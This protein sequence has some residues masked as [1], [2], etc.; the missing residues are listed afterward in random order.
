MELKEVKYV[1]QALANGRID[2]YIFGGWALDILRGRKTRE[3]RDLD[4]C[5]MSKD[6]PMLNQILGSEHFSRVK[7]VDGR[8]EFEHESRK[9]TVDV[10]KLTPNDS[11]LEVEHATVIGMQAFSYP[12]RQRYI[13][14]GEKGVVYYPADIFTHQFYGKSAGL[15][16][17]PLEALFFDRFH[18]EYEADVKY[19]NSLEDKVSKKHLDDTFFVGQGSVVNP[20]PQ[21]KESRGS[22]AF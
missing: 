14:S 10:L 17:L 5:V 12:K 13:R 16:L 8:Q 19:I 21:P 18:Y 1:V 9:Y 2:S 4:L 22:K 15:R 20:V 11:A 3:H 6:F 7:H